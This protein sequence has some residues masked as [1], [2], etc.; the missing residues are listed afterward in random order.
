MADL[1][2]LTAQR[3]RLQEIRFKGVDSYSIS[4][5]SMSYRS[6]EELGAAIADLDRRIAALSSKQVRRIVVG[7]TKGF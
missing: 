5:R 7:T 2:T 6:D 4:G 1:A 3:D